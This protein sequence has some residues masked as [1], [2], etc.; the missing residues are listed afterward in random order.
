M[1]GA[2]AVCLSHDLK[3]DLSLRVGISHSHF[4]LSKDMDCDTIQKYTLQLS[5]DAND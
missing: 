3:S 4:Y 1:V 5:E 2:G